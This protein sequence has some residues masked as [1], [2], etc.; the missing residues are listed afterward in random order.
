MLSNNHLK[1]DD[2]GSDTSTE[3]FD[4]NEKVLVD[5]V[6]RAKVAYFGSVHF[7]TDDDWVGIEFDEPIGKHNGS[8]S[9]HQYFQCPS[10]HGLFVRSHRLQRCDSNGHVTA[11]VKSPY[12][13]ERRPIKTSRPELEAEDDIF[14]KVS[15]PEAGG[16]YEVR[17][18]TVRSPNQT[19]EVSSK[20]SKFVDSLENESDQQT[21]RIHSSRSPTPTHYRGGAKSKPYGITLGIGENDH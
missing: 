3:H 1:D 2:S 17:V 14:A 10:M 6:K 18:G 13:I 4:R 20:L 16:F 8:I 9:G 12:R 15:Q 19:D 11:R 7:S 5:G 21:I